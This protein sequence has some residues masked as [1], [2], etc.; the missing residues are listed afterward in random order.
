M[1]DRT[2]NT[3]AIT[4][5]QLATLCGVTPDAVRKW[6]RNKEVQTDRY[7]RVRLSDPAVQKY[8]TDKQRERLTAAKP[9]PGTR[10][11]IVRKKSAQRTPPPERKQTHSEHVESTLT[12]EEQ[13]QLH[14]NE[15]KLDA[16]VR[17]LEAQA[18]AHE[19]KNQVARGALGDIKFLT[20]LFYQQLHYAIRQFVVLPQGTMDDLIALVLERGKAARTECI[21]LQNEMINQIGLETKRGWEDNM[22]RIESDLMK[23]SES[24]D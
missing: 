13:R 5:Q 18:T 12:A 6:I 2:T 7:H 16:E 20:S 8:M 24:D 21:N 14:R 11:D 3:D 1:A 9:P 22:K 23:L 10:N 17:K 19:I 4:S 15:R